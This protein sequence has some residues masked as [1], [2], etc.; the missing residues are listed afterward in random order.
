MPAS[1]S[2]ASRPSPA[3]RASPS[4]AAARAGARSSATSS[5]ESPLATAS[6]ARDRAS[7]RGRN[8]PGARRLRLRRRGSHRSKLPSRR[9]QMP[10]T[11][12]PPETPVRR[13]R[14]AAPAGLVWRR[15][16]A[17]LILGGEKSA[18][19]AARHLVKLA[20][21]SSRI[22]RATTATGA[23]PA[24]RPGAPPR[25]AGIP[26][27]CGLTGPPGSPDHTGKAAPPRARLI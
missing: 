12:P 7:D 2:A 13:R 5:A 17:R 10:R 8:P 24:H 25:R 15:H 27:S 19:R 11:A 23:R 14:R 26:A 6:R 3:L 16:G 1:S 20:G 9:G 22:T 4:A 18:E 21:A